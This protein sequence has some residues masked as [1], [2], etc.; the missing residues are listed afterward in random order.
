MRAG[1]E[2]QGFRLAFWEVKIRATI[3]PVSQLTAVKNSVETVIKK[4][5]LLRAIFAGGKSFLVSLARTFYALWLE[6]TGLMFAVFAVMGGS[7]LLK[8][9]RAD[10]F[11][12]RHRMW[13][14]AAFTLVCAWFTLA[15]FTRAKR[16]RKR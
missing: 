14:V 1:D 9:Y 2:R 10:H 6:V 12:D 3:A 4:D 16:T 13:T 5:R 15:S 8:Q 7:R 11:A